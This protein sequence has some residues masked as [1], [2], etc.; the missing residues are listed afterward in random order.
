MNNVKCRFECEKPVNHKVCKEDFCW[1]P[2]I[3]ARECDK[4]WIFSRTVSINS[5]NGRDNCFI[6][7]ILFVINGL[8]LLVTTIITTQNISYILKKLTY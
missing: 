5:I 2:N 3:Y 4:A 8:F 7:T 6:S 1:N